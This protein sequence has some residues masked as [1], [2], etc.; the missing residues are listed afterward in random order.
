MK[1]R[2]SSSPQR[3]SATLLRASLYSVLSLL[4]LLSYTEIAHRFGGLPSI[5]PAWER[6]IPLLLY[7]FFYMILITRPS[8]WQPVIAALPVV[9]IYAIFDIYHV[10][11][12]RLLRVIE[13]S[14]LPEMIIV[15]SW[16]SKILLVLS[17]GLLGLIMVRQVAWRRPRPLI[18]GMIPL[19][20]LAV[21]V[22]FFP[23]RFMAGFERIKKPIHW[24]SDTEQA[25]RNGRINIALYNEARRVSSLKRTIGYRDNPHY[26]TMFAAAIHT[27][28]GMEVRRNVH[29]IVLESFLDPTLLA[30]VTFSR[31]PI[32]PDFQALFQQRG[33]FSRSPVFGGATAQ[34]EF[35]V[36]CG[37]PALRELSGIEFDV[38]TGTRTLC[39]PNI[40]SEAGYQTIATNAFYPD[41]FNAT[42]AYRGL[43]FAS[44]N[45]PREFA[46]VGGSYFAT[47][48][49]TGESYLYDGALFSQNLDHV[50]TW[51]KEHPGVPL[52]NYVMTI[53]GH[54]PHLIN[55]DKRPLMVE[56]S[57]SG[58]CRDRQLERSVNQFYYRTGEIAAYARELISLDP[59]SIIIFVSDHL[60]SLTYGPI[61]YR[62]LGYLGNDDGATTLNRL[63]V[64]ENGRPIRF[65]T[66]HH[67][68]IPGIILGYLTENQVN[69]TLA[70]SPDPHQTRNS[71]AL[72]TQ[73][74]TVMAHAMHGQPLGSWLGGRTAHAR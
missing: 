15:L 20:S 7:L 48:D 44:I 2:H 71:A 49:T 23:E 50:R 29:L 38:F 18:W 16:P 34:A 13:V 67:Y 1:P 28:Q 53:Y 5:L 32:H 55:H 3:Q 21:A 36:L 57:C 39:L 66:I 64:I 25:R 47:G 42:K 74:L 33:G 41:F 73:Y 63:Y 58:T 46:P 43:G 72:R 14:E 51:M 40:L 26:L 45:F 4:F 56:L 6:E 10:L 12:G 17:V 62:D 19:L 30:G 52:L 60:P 9:F 69:N 68:D 35:E 11:F 8:H 22:E 61:T 24:M 70:S 37:V 27:L 54:T 59:Q 65:E 31:N